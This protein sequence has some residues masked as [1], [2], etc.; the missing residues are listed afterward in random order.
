M[1]EL[2][3]K[4]FDQLLI[5]LILL[6]FSI[7]GRFY[8]TI[9]NQTWVNTFSHTATIIILPIVT[10]IITKVIS[11]NIA[12]SLGMVGALSIVRFRNPVRSPFELTVYFIAITMGITA[13][14]D[15]RWLIFFSISLIVASICLF[16]VNFLYKRWKNKTLFEISFSEGNSLS[17]LE[18]QSK[19]PI[20]ELEDS[21]FLISERK[22]ESNYGYILASNN[23]NYL[24]DILKKTSKNQFI[25]SY[26]LNA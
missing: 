7:I 15:V 9:L 21:S 12:L 18:I 6:F 8:L 19:K 4:F 23:I 24:K 11:G 16:L 5:I 1:H 25:K 14:V 17:T 22:D 13:S 2:I 26:H 3:F 10:F 20:K